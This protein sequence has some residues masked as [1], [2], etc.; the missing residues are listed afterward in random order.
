MYPIWRFFKGSESNLEE[1]NSLKIPRLNNSELEKLLFFTLLVLEISWFWQKFR[2][3]IKILSILDNK[4]FA[5]SVPSHCMSCHFA[6]PYVTHC[7]VCEKIFFKH[8]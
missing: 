7:A 5:K 8:A 2:L 6:M 1:V 4:Q 3:S